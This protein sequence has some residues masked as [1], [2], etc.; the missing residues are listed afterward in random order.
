[1]Y[2][3]DLSKDSYSF[4]N[5][6]Y[7]PNHHSRMTGLVCNLNDGPTFRP[8]RTGDIVKVTIDELK[9]GRA[10]LLL[11]SK[12]SNSVYLEAKAIDESVTNHLVLTLQSKPLCPDLYHSSPTNPPANK[13]FLLSFPP[14]TCPI[15]PIPGDC[16]GTNSDPQQN[17]ESSANDD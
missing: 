6:P 11:W 9:D 10:S 3:L 5:T 16:C 15:S 7:V 8:I 4:G 12:E 14:A 2:E 13:L 1:M 17:R